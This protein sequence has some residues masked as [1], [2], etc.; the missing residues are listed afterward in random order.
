M[1]FGLINP[2]EQKKL[3]VKLLD[4]YKKLYPY[5]KFTRK[6]KKLSLREL[7]ELFYTYDGEEIVATAEEKM[8]MIR[9]AIEQGYSTPLILLKKK[10]KLILLDGHRRVR[11]ALEQKLGWKALIIIPSKDI[12]FGIEKIIQGKV[13]SMFK[14]KTKKRKKK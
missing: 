14:K 11:V 3:F 7:K 5:V 8:H 6:E 13:K 4:Y 10:K 12:E 1:V 2:K 9:D